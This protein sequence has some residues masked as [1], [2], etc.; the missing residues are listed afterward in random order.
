MMNVILLAKQMQRPVKIHLSRSRAIILVFAVLLVPVSVASYL[1]FYWGGQY[2]EKE[3]VL[4]SS[5]DDAT[6][7]ADRAGSMDM[8]KEPREVR[9]TINALTARLGV[10]QAQVIRLNALGKRLVDM[11]GLEKGEF[12]FSSPPPQGGPE[13]P[14]ILNEQPLPLP[15]LKQSVD[16]LNQEVNNRQEQLSVLETMFRHRNLLDEV[17][18][19]GRPVSDGWISSYFGYR[20]NP[21]TG[22]REWHPGIDIAGEMGEPVVAVAAGIVTYAG[23]HGGYGNLVQINHGNGFVTRYGHNSKVLVTVG[24]TVSKGQ[25]VALMGSTGRST[26]PHVH[27]EVWRSGRV[28]NPLKY[29]SAAN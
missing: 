11:A 25:E 23:K 21:F 22:G 24:Q 9:E 6:A 10:L 16:H 14:K 13:Q 18:P 27:F 17:L 29:L 4:T 2:A 15:T 8:N 3:K 19:K 5:A 28:V 26:G 1:G 12:D 7:S 20:T